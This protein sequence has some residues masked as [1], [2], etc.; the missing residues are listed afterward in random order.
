MAFYLSVNGAIEGCQI[1]EGDHLYVRY[2]LVYGKDWSFV[3]GMETGT[4][5]IAK[6]PA[7]ADPVFVW[8][9]PIDF[10]LKS[11]NAFGWPRLVVSVIG[12]S[13]MGNEVI[14]GYS[15]MLLPTTEGRHVR[16]SSLYTPKSSSLCRRI[17]SWIMATPPEFFEPTFVAQGTGREVTR[18][19]SSGTVK[20]VVNVISKHMSKLGYNSHGNNSNKNKNSELISPKVSDSRVRGLFS[21]GT[22]SSKSRQI[23]SNSTN[24]RSV[25]TKSLK[26]K[27]DMKLN[28]S[29]KFS[30][31]GNVTGKK[32]RFD[33]SKDRKHVK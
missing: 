21:P 16:Y 27:E 29:S 25:L 15:S 3:H 23:S 8:N 1:P 2:A 26:S 9:H 31:L 11:T 7:G 22:F 14:K 10:T 12:H 18:V 19:T 6:R 33:S 17:T 4:S 24:G 32:T 30:S 20:I 5:Q 13:M 28:T